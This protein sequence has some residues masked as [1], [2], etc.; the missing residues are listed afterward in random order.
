MY[1]NFIS[2]E[3]PLAFHFLH[4]RTDKYQEHAWSHTKLLFFPYLHYIK[5][6]IYF[7]K[8]EKK[9]VSTK[10]GHVETDSSSTLVSLH[11]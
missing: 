1:T 9:I 10:S 3:C 4:P 6:G 8:K 2:V 7:L 5:Q 11:L